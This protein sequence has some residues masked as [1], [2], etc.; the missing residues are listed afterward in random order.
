MRTERTVTEAGSSTEDT[1]LVMYSNTKILGQK[2][3]EEIHS[4]CRRF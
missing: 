2:V 3:I 4:V 1:E